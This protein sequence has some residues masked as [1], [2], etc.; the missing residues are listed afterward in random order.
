MCF[1]TSLNDSSDAAVL[2]PPVIGRVLLP[3]PPALLP[4]LPLPLPLPLPTC[5]AMVETTYVATPVAIKIRMQYHVI[6]VFGWGGGEYIAPLTSY[7]GA[8]AGNVA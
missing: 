6:T 7:T 1:I 3:F 4:P 2:P 5:S 8:V